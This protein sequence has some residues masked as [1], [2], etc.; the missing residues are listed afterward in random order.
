MMTAREL[1][2]L[3]EQLEDK[4]VKVHVYDEDGEMGEAHGIEEYPYGVI[5][6]F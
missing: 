4:S 3:L 6:L 1:I 5:E 2:D